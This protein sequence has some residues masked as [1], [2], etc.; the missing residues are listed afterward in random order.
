MKNIFRPLM[1]AILAFVC[2]NLSSCKKYLDEKPRSSLAIASSLS[3]YQALLEQPNVIN[4]NDVAAGEVSA[5]EVYMTDADYLTRA[6]EDQRMY[7]WQNSRAFNAAVNDWFYTYSVIYRANTVIEGVNDMKLTK[8]NADEWKNVSGQG[9]YYRAKSFLGALGN[10][11]PAYG[12]DAETDLGIPLKLGTNFNEQTTRSTV[13]ACYARVVLDLQKAISLLPDKALHVVRPSKPAAYGLMARTMLLMGNYEAAAKYADTCLMLKSDLMDFNTL[14]PSATYPVPVFNTE[15]MAASK[16][17]VLSVVNPSR[18]KIVLELYNSYDNNDL[19]KTIY[20]KNNGNGSFA[21]KGSYDGSASPF[22]GMAIDEVY[23][24]RAECRARLNQIDGS[25][26]D[27]NALLVKRYKTGTFVSIK[28]TGPSALLPII[29]MERRKELVLRGLRWLDIKRL[30]RDGAN[31][32]LKRTVNGKDYLLT[33]GSARFA[34][35]IPEDVIELSG[36]K[37]N[38]Y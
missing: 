32:N 27:L 37:Q 18:G 21:F 7:T 12:Q 33:A 16:L 8:E 9:Y 11:A 29:L 34:M 24:T 6:E 2:M 28:T 38:V 20:F 3:D 17:T 15:V 14:T 25:L 22:G 1:M 13:A 23:L 19:R 36:I 35:P 10:W 4:D 31:I 30:N 26:A 5:G